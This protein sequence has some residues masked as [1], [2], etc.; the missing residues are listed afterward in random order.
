MFT[1]SLDSNELSIV[2]L[3]VVLLHWGGSGL[4]P[5]SVAKE[6]LQWLHSANLTLA[7]NNGSA[8]WQHAIKTVQTNLAPTCT[9]QLLSGFQD[10]S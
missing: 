6:T 9:I 5:Y 10:L 8:L 4:F 7:C 3:Q 1:C 2:C